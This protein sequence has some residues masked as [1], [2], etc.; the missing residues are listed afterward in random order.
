MMANVE[1]GLLQSGFTPGE[2]YTCKDLLTAA[3]PLV[4]AVWDKGNVTFTAGWPVSR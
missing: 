2:D 4:M 1:D 3:M